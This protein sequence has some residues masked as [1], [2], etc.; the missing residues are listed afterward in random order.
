MNVLFIIKKYAFQLRLSCPGHTA[1][2]PEVSE[3][4]GKQVRRNIMPSF[5]RAIPTS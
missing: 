4:K 2:V 5:M 1:Q 3:L